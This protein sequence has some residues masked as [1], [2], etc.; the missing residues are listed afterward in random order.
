M[1]DGIAVGGSVRLVN[2]SCTDALVPV[3]PHLPLRLHD[4][5]WCLRTAFRLCAPELD[6]DRNN[7]S[8]MPLLSRHLGS[9]L[10]GLVVLLTGS[11]RMRH[12]PECFVFVGGCC[13]FSG[14]FPLYTGFDVT[15]AMQFVELS[16]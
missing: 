11:D 16:F 1:I 15:P 7:M 4:D 14:Y 10:S 13:G 8:G 9:D 5:L 12:W 2:L 6:N 3:W